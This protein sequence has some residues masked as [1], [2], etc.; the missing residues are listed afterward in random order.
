M[1]FLKFRFESATKFLHH[2]IFFPTFHKYFRLCTVMDTDM[3]LPIMDI[4][5]LDTVDTDT[6]TT[7]TMVDVAMVTVLLCPVLANKNIFKNRK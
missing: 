4:M 2:Y 7:D 5:V 6:D 3:L 1:A